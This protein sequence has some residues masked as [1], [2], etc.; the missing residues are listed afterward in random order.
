MIVFHLLPFSINSKFNLK[1]FTQF[2]I[3]QEQYVFD[4]NKVLAGPR[5]SQDKSLRNPS[6][7]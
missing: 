1:L 3:F 6:N 5:V 2:L 7:R 4:L